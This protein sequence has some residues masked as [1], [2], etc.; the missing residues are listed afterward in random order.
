MNTP[1][2]AELFPAGELLADELDARGWTQADFAEILGRPAQFVSEILSGKK[3]ITRESASQIG[4]ALGT[5][6]EFWLN[7]Q[8]SYFLWRQSQD[9]EMLENLDAVKTRARLQDL[10]PI[11]LL[12]KRGFITS[13]DVEVQKSQVLS[14]FGKTS[15]DDP[16]TISFSARR[17]N[18][19]EGVTVLQHAW[20][21]C[22]KTIGKGLDAA[23][24]SHD[25]LLN[26]AKTLSNRVRE[27]QVI[28]ELQDMFA[29]VGVKLVYIDSFPGGELDGCAMIVDGH[30]VIGLSGRG[31]RLDK[32]LFTLLHEV[33][34]IL[35]G[36]LEDNGEVILD[37]LSTDSIDKE[38]EA[39]Q[40]AS[41]LAISSPLPAIPER[42]NSTWIEQQASELK[43]APIV[44][45]GRLQKEG[46]LSWK[47]TLVRNAPTATQYLEHWKA[48]ILINS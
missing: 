5:S 23:E 18:G 13:N 32:V 31:K 29:V 16:S 33:A 28:A 35:L 37:D 3:E 17:S 24:F 46:F 30:P 19:D 45:I 44:L 14:L 38:N 20:A 11:S 15:F 10:A 39:D 25:A 21:A 36:H 6:A 40:L 42:V 41:S 22:V 48:P 47:T 27:P 7:L 9:P 8:D 2:A 26:L 34:H 4:A 43:V 1:I 12:T